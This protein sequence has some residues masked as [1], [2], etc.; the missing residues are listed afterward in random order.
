M[1]GEVGVPG[2][3]EFVGVGVVAALVVVVMGRGTV[4][5]LILRSARGCRFLKRTSCPARLREL[6]L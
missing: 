2:A 5:R 6:W 3:K 1:A 4:Q